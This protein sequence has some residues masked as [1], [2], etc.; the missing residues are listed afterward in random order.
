MQEIKYLRGPSAGRMELSWCSLLLVDEKGQ[1][2]Q[3]LQKL[4]K[5]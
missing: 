2:L 3:R 1:G 4:R 5:S